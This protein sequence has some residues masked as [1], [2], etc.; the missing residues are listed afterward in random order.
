MTKSMLAAQLTRHDPDLRD[1]IVE[2]AEVPCP[3]PGPGEV[4]VRLGAAGVCRT[5][6]H[7]AS[8]LAIGGAS[9]PLPHILGH[10]N[11]G[12]IAAVGEGVERSWLGRAVVCYPFRTVGDELIERYGEESL[13]AEGSRTTAGINAPGGFAEYLVTSVR[14]LVALPED[15]QVMRYAPLAD[16]GLTA[17][18]A[19]RR[20]LDG[21]HPGDAT[22][23]IG[24]GGV[25][26]LVVQILLALSAPRVIVADTR[27]AARDLVRRY[28][29]AAACEPAEVPGVLAELSQGR[30][31]ATI[32][33]VGDDATARLGIGVLRPGGTYTCVGIGGELRIPTVELVE[34]EL[35]VQ[36]SFTGSYTDLVEVARLVD[37]GLVE[38]EIVTV[39]LS[40]A[41]HA[42]GELRDGR[43]TGRT[44]LTPDEALAESPP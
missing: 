42:L 9:V 10:E 26:H 8:G 3:D 18:R 34:P 6:L 25:G 41:A 29:V 35:R 5:D 36:G 12:W 16:A 14:C 4:L 27:E 24:A 1:P 17:Y 2:L 43:V 28:D 37:L 11:A 44:V 15:A 13:T 32:D 40:E 23:V 22:L 39:P 38:P 7:L 21:L 20:T 19:C 31:A 30:V 33:V